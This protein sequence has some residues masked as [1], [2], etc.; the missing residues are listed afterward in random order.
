MKRMN[1]LFG[2]T[3]LL[4]GITGFLQASSPTHEENN[5]ISGEIINGYRVL[6][7]TNTQDA[8]HLI[9]Y[10]GDYVKFKFNPEMDD[11]ILSIPALSIQKKLPKGLNE[12]PYFKMKR[13]GSFDFSFG[14]IVGKIDVIEYSQENYIEFTSGKA[15]EFIKTENP[16]IL[17]VRMPFEFKKGHL[18][19]AVLI[20]VQ[21]LAN[22]IKELSKHKN[23]D[24]LIYC[25]TG[26]RSTVASKILIDSGF[27]RIYNL[28][29]GIHQ[30]SLDRYPVVY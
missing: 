2:C 6:T 29:Y 10:R 9:V 23:S 15:A 11:P 13:T 27:K 26:N 14:D 1:L 17:D 19:N 5:R 18:Q 12:A 3:I 21:E 30:W 22:R 4:L 24:I 20:P 25:A 7:L 16:I 8:R 28:R